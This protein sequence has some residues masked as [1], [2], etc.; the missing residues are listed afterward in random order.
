MTVKKIVFLV[1]P[2]LL[3]PLSISAQQF[4]PA[5]EEA[6]VSLFSA[7]IGDADVSLFLFG[8]WDL[9]LTGSLG[10]GYNSEL[11]ELKL[12]TFPGMTPGVQFKQVP[13]LTI[14]LWLLN[15]Y[16]FEATILED[17]EF[18][19]F[20]LGYQGTEDDFLRSVR[21]GNA[22][23]AMDS[24]GY[25]SVSDP[26]TNSLGAY[27]YMESET[28]EHEL[29]IRY[30]P[31]EYR[32]KIFIGG[33]EVLEND[34]SLN[35][36][37]SGQYFILPDAGI[38][39]ITV[40]LEDPEG[41]L[42]GSDGRFYRTADSG[43]VRVDRD[44]GLLLFPDPVT[45]RI[46]VSYTVDG[47]SV[48]D[49]SLGTD[50]LPAE[51]AGLI[52]PSGDLRDF[53]WTESF[54]G[55][56][57]GDF[58]IEIGGES[59][60]LIQRP[61]LF[62]PFQMC[63]GY[64][65]TGGGDESSAVSG[66][67][68]KKDNAY[69]AGTDIPLEYDAENE[70]LTIFFPGIPRRDPRNRYPFAD[71]YPKNYGPD[72]E[73][74]PGYFG[75]FLRIQVLKEAD[76]YLLDSDALEGSVQVRINGKPETRF[77]FD[78]QSGEI[79]FPV[80]VFPDDTIEIRYKSGTDS[81]SGN[82]NFGFGNRFILLP[83][84]TL[85]GGLGV[86]WNVV[87]GA[88]STKPA[89]SPGS[90][91]LTGQLEYEQENFSAAVKAGFSLATPDTRGLFRITG[92]EE[93]GHYFDI[94]DSNI[95]PSS[96]P[97][98]AVDPSGTIS[99]SSGNRGRLVYKNFR[100]YNF[101]TGTRLMP[102]SWDP[103][104]SNIFPYESGSKTGPYTAATEAEGA[105]SKVM[106]MDL[107]LTP[108]LP[109]AGGQIRLSSEPEGVDLST[110]ESISFFYRSE[111][112]EEGV[113]LFLHAGSL[114]EDLDGDGF[115]D[116]EDSKD[117][118]G[119]EFN[120]S[121]SGYTL[122]LGGGPDGGGNDRLDTEDINGN[123]LLDRD[124]QELMVRKE[125]PVP[126]SDWQLAEIYLSADERAD[127]GRTNAL[128]LI[129]YNPNGGST[130]GR[131]MVGGISLE[132][133]SLYDR[134]EDPGEV[135]S[136]EIYEFQTSA[137]ADS[138][139][140]SVFPE[141]EENFHADGSGQKVLEI[142]WTDIPEGGEWESIKYTGEMP[143]EQYRTF[144]FYFRVPEGAAEGPHLSVHI[145]DAENAGLFCA[146]QLPADNRWHRAEIDLI[147]ETA[148]I[149][150][151]IS[152][153]ASVNYQAP[154]YNPSKIVFT[155]TGSEGILYIDEF[156]L[157]ESLPSLGAGGEGV[158]NWQYPGSILT[159]GAFPLLGN[160]SIYQKIS[161]S[162]RQFGSGFT[163]DGDGGNFRSL[164]ETA[165]NLAVFRI[166]LTADLFYTAPSLYVSGGHRIQFPVQL[167]FISLI[168][169][170]KETNDAGGNNFTK[171]ESLMLSIPNGMSLS[172]SRETSGRE[173][174]LSQQWKA[175]VTTRLQIP[176]KFSGNFNLGK[177]SE[178]FSRPYENYF[179]NWM[180]S[181]S[182]FL[183]WQEYAYPQ[184]TWRT[185]LTL[186]VTTLPVGAAISHGLSFDQYG[187]S[188]RL[189]RNDT[190]FSISLPVTFQAGTPFAW[191][192]ST[193]YGRTMSLL[194][195]VPFGTGFGETFSI[196][197]N[198]YAGQ[199]Y[200]YGSIPYSEL[201]DNSTKET[202]RE[203]TEGIETARYNPEAFLSLSRKSGSRLLDLFLPSEGSIS[204]GRILEREQDDIMSGREWDFRIRNTALNLFGRLGAYPFLSFYET[205][206]ISTIVDL[207]VDLSDTYSVTGVETV[208]QNLF[209][210]QGAADW[211]L[212]IE[213]RVDFSYAPGEDDVFS[214]ADTI[215]A[216]FIW[217]VP[218][219][220]SLPF[221]FIPEKNRTSL[222]FQSTESLETTLGP[223][224]SG[225]AGAISVNILISHQTKLVVPESGFLSADITLGFDRSSPYSWYIGV[226]GGIQGKISF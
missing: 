60:L 140:E 33:N 15:R 181:Y 24:Y 218:A 36:Y 208:I 113:R 44:T 141:V 128:R 144:S 56:P 77:S 80:P 50:F 182:Y 133:S 59:A 191:N 104:P 71:L 43:E 16:F 39:R 183:P 72:R 78:P 152:E 62:S 55:Q 129:V 203:D 26:P 198:D 169:S 207:S 35:G 165:V 2:L 99:V 118:G 109:W 189:Q 18:N 100:V 135:R 209:F 61:G 51:A 204:F 190:D 132:S 130:D 153:S 70:L 164:T 79:T 171:G 47:L 91:L 73:Q 20:L 161:G 14:S 115:L 156:H 124:V 177:I 187:I 215:L 74:K 162:S 195:T 201:F 103:P 45:G 89:E 136:R 88:Y 8:S 85:E 123:G 178:E 37:R 29:L 121:A 122:L 108:E 27:A 11:K 188:R 175:D 86:V 116:E 40:F 225:E 32:E 224:F 200:F 172:L 9:S 206:E 3:L 185:D 64:A 107:L 210:I 163:F 112:L 184:Q 21:I 10:L 63:N 154:S 7:E 5:E 222:Y 93:S 196:Y 199:E 170:Y 52:D 147:E 19:T 160:F 81:R 143:L 173:A 101:F 148:S 150:G 106:V 97:S 138:F 216:G 31:S 90:L 87:D 4:I 41:N 34:F 120:D 158:V 46:A 151:E 102:Y 30:D 84:L 42:S 157:S 105:E 98:A 155:G 126:G 197:G 58:S 96:V 213:N 167:Q 48:G 92:M 220:F 134:T 68:L 194:R 127:L 75:H 202:F 137:S 226:Q 149:D 212:S 25:L 23:I 83:G 159:A 94:S 1:L 38:D 139:L 146:I 223:R 217:R 117:A 28:T 131:L 13:D 125:L 168:D 193:G 205:E 76:S 142:S 82:I 211:E 186:E 57:L 22:E 53:S 114:S 54:L 176:L 67:L 214:T 145:T 110:A 180:Q 6:P 66:T 192:I 95:Y 49:E 65:F 17:S 221:E 219:G 12:A 119:F 111:G 69:A 179:S 166:T 174:I